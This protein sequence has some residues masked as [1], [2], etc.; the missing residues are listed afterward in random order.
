MSTKLYL[1]DVV[2]ETGISKRNVKYWCQKYEL[3]VEKD[4]RKN[5]YPADTINALR[6]VKLLSGSK[7]FNHRFIRLQIERAFGRSEA[8]IELSENYERARV[9][10][11]ELLQKFSR[12]TG[13]V[14]LPGLSKHRSETAARG[15][16]KKGDI[17]DV[18]L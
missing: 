16:G 7:L 14:L 12:P 9:E 13:T 5:V 11:R 15:E 8:E 10:G 2:E 17:D 4:G 3:P 18:L 6:L 1:D